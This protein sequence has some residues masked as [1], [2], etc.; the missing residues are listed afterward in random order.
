MK[1]A[2][3][4]ELKKYNHYT[5]EERDEVINIIEQLEAITAEQG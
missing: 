5:P 1:N 2:L 3:M 4:E